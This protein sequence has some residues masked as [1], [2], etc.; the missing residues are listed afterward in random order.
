MNHGARQLWLEV[1]E[2]NARAL[3]LYVH[4]GFRHIG[5]RRGYY[6]AL[7]GRREGASVMALE[8][9]RGRHVE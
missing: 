6:P 9:D 7:H 5:V 8:I 4:Y 1:R 3:R 2:S